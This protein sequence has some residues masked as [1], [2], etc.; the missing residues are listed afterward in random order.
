MRRA[1]TRSDEEWDQI[2]RRF[3]KS[4]LLQREFCELEGIPRSTFSKRHSRRAKRKRRTT[5][6]R[7]ISPTTAEAE[8]PTSFIPLEVVRP[9]ARQ[10][11]PS[12]LR[13]DS[14]EL[15]VELPMGIV[16][17]FRGMPA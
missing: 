16:L 4:G 15:V 10:T 3:D 6:T 9:S 8:N 14:P 5:T 17:R 2:M 12:K 11:P 13:G 1:A 7:G